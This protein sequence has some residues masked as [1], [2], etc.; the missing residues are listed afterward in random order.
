V[1]RTLT[2]LKKIKDP[3]FRGEE[4]RMAE[5]SQTNH[6]L[7][8][9]K[10]KLLQEINKLSNIYFSLKRGSEKVKQDM[11]GFETDRIKT[12]EALGREVNL[13]L[14]EEAEV[15]KKRSEGLD[16]DQLFLEELYDYAS[17]L[18][19]IMESLCVDYEEKLAETQKITN[20]TSKES[21]KLKKLIKDYEERTEKTKTL[22]EVAEMKH[23]K[24]DSLLKEVQEGIDQKKKEWER[25]DD[26]LEI[27]RA[28]LRNMKMLYRQKE[29]KLKKRE[30]A[31]GDKERAFQRKLV[32][33][34]M[35]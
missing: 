20:D 32:E 12:L 34:K 13:E 7:I 16:Q 33:L 28:E 5:T 15:L 27:E 4:F 22:L 10:S 29:E 31:L 24:V 26:K 18:M 35:V 3:F 21:K 2:S 25:K 8:E 17:E 9:Q 19:P 6:E 23:T 30:K 1:D 11:V 14:D